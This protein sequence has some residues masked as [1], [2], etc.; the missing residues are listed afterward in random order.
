MGPA[1]GAQFRP[2]QLRQQ[3]SLQRRDGDGLVN[4][5]QPPVS[6]A[7]GSPTAGACITGGVFYNGSTF[8]A[9]HRNNFFFGDFEGGQI[10][11]SVLDGSHTTITS[12]TFFATGLGQL[13]DI[14]V[15]PDGALYYVGRTGGAVG[16]I[17]Y[18][19]TTPQN[20]LVSTNALG[21]NE[22]SSAA[23]TVRL[24]V[25]PAA[26]VTVNVAWSSGDPDVAAAPASLTFTASTW[27]TPQTVTVSAAP[28]ADT[29]N[30]GATITCSSTGLMSQN[31]AITVTDT[32]VVNG[33]PAATISQ[34]VNGAVVSGAAAEFFG[35]GTDPQ[36][37][38]TLVRAEFFI[39]DLVT[40]VYGDNAAGGHYH[41]GGGHAM[42]DTRT[43]TNGPHVL[44][45]TVVDS[46]GLR[47]SHQ[48]TVT[49][50]N[51]S[52]GGA[53]VFQQDP[54]VDGTVSIEAENY[55]AKADR[56]DAWTAVTAPAGFSGSG[57][58]QALPNDGTTYADAAA[59]Y[60][61]S[62]PQLDYRV[63][64]L[65]PGTYG[66]WIRGNGPTGSDDSVHV[67]LDGQAVASAEAIDVAQGGGYVWSNLAAAGTAAITV[68]TAGVHVLNV[69]M[70]EDGFILDK[71]VLTLDTGFTPAG[72]GPAQSGRV[73]DGDF[74]GMP[75]SAE[76][77]Y[78]LDPAGADQD[79][80][81]VPDGQNDWN[82]N[83]VSNAMDVAQGSPPGA[84]GAGGGGS[85]GG[86]GCG[87]TGME[88]VIL[89]GFLAPRRRPRNEGDAS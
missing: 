79:G 87:G 57:A 51:S 21:V 88:V 13:V 66:V 67:G 3:C 32:T 53:L 44:R 80:D 64:F 24:A 89:A 74:D 46:G 27:N 63:N 86:G 40:P 73:S 23:F 85:G 77:A 49:V 75:D 19:G 34:P 33:A 35:N 38:G 17:E 41:L 28:D 48:I 12:T 10:M 30:D 45:M 58:L 25:A 56:G 37:V 36:G 29:I 55:D 78:G 42:W 11:R 15:G 2:E 7:F 26:N 82:S 68:S 50:D 9:T 39:D 60:T 62:S 76:S 65:R 1:A 5:N 14:D 47:G 83:G 54:G 16:R 4:L 43:L 81:G 8:P 31:V 52:P 22:G 20:I 59:N 18:T 69:W 84:P 70:R 61:A 72:G 6:I 71:I